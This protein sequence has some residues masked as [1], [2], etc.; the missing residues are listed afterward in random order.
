MKV[1]NSACKNVLWCSEN[2]WLETGGQFVWGCASVTAES[3]GRV[4]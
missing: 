4:T 1:E 2:L 3:L